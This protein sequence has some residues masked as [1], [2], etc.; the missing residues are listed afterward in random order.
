[1][2]PADLSLTVLHAVRRAVDDGALRVEVP[3]R[4]KVERARPGGSGE[5]ASNVALVLARSAGR[6]AR[7][8]AGIIEERLRDAPGLRGVEIT[9]PGF[10]NFTLRGDAGSELVRV[11]RAAGAS[12]GHGTALAGT[13]VRFA[14]V[15]ESRAVLVTEV[16]VRLLRSQ[17]A[18]VDPGVDVGERVYVHPGAYEVERLG[19]DAARWALLR[20]APHDRPLDGA[21][22]L[23]QHERNSLFRVRYAYSRVRRLL[24]NG[25]QLGVGPAPEVPVDAPVLLGVLGDHPAVLLAAARHRAPDRVARHLEAL[26]DALLAFQHTVLPLGDEKPSAAHRSRLALAE[27]AGTVLAGGLSVLGI[28]APDRI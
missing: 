7:E 2:T 28:S 26:A 27:A 11:V 21:P 20:A 6:S 24:V 10:L 9:G 14:E 15:T 22:L 18:D 13:T 8:V 3:P 16:V 1:M 4:I 19:S 17:G 12:Y 5:Y 23:A 25:E